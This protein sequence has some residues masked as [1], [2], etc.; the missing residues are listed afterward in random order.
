MLP[1]ALREAVGRVEE[2]VAGLAFGEASLRRGLQPLFPGGGL[3]R[4]ACLDCSMST[5]LEA[6]GDRSEPPSWFLLLQAS[7]GCGGAALRP[8]PFDEGCR[9]KGLSGEAWGPGRTISD[10]VL[11]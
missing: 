6:S 3:S 4:P 9:N 5:E 1:F 11:G 7:K 8:Q 10:F 2:R